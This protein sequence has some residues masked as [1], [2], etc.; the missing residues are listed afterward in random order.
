MGRGPRN[1][2][3]AST[4]PRAHV[5]TSRRVHRRLFQLVVC[6]VLA[7]AVFIFARLFTLDASADDGAMAMITRAIWGKIHEPRRDVKLCVPT[8]TRPGPGSTLR[9]GEK[10]ADDEA[11]PAPRRST[12]G[13]MCM[14]RRIF[15]GELLFGIH[16]IQSAPGSNGAFAPK[17]HERVGLKGHLAAGALECTGAADG[18][19]GT[20]TS[21]KPTTRVRA[22]LERNVWCL[23]LE[24]ADTTTPQSEI[25]ASG[26][27]VQLFGISLRSRS[28]EEPPTAPAATVTVATAAIISTAVKAQH[29][30]AET[31]RTTSV[32][33]SISSSTT[34]TSATPTT[35]STNPTTVAPPL[36]PIAE[37]VACAGH[38]AD[39]SG[40][41]A[42]P[43]APNTVAVL[44]SIARCVVPP[45]PE[46]VL[47]P[48]RIRS[49]AP[50]PAISSPARLVRCTAV[51]FN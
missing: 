47:D 22:V 13:G 42:T 44:L 8:R 23:A 20:R 7:A 2:P 43:L 28:A 38:W 3:A 14:R 27:F 46:D 41:V 26:A 33:A 25:S 34:T 21:I 40:K 49:L 5:P 36:R 4:P 29:A 24:P 35:T 50:L 1:A 6:V 37:R 48:K 17:T 19:A 15:A 10:F 16:R 31:I 32:S 9:V 39:N 12:L 45:A 30:A 18:G 11:E 51:H